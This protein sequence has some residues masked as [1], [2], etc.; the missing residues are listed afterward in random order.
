MARTQVTKHNYQAQDEYL[1]AAADNKDLVRFTIAI[2]KIFSM[3]FTKK[4]A[5]FSIC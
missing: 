4:V 2:K 5:V 1:M 3:K